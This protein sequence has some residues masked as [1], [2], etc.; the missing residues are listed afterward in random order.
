MV[1]SFTFLMV[2][3]F[4]MAL[5]AH[6]QMYIGV[7]PNALIPQNKLSETNIE[8]FGFNIVLESRNYCKLWYG[9]RT[10][11]ISFSKIEDLPADS[12]YFQNALYIS[13]QVRFNIFG[14]DCY[15]DKVIPY[16]QAM[17][18]FSSIGNTDERSRFGIGGA[19]GGGVTMGFNMLHLCW[20]LDINA[21]W[22][23]PNSIDRAD[24][25]QSIQSVNLSITLSVGL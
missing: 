23:A 1:K 25:R 5:P 2:T 15:N 22:S 11:Y 10:D 13:P 3:I 9:L 21:L 17:F 14:G 24:K 20:L 18:T 7:G 16:L 4:M 19:G 8:S 12:N 6:S